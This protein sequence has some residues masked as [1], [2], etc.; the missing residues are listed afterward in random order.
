MVTPHCLSFYLLF[1]LNQNLSV[2]IKIPRKKNLNQ[3]SPGTVRDI[4]TGVIVSGVDTLKLST[5]KGFLLLFAI[6]KLLDAFL[7]A[8][9]TTIHAKAPSYHPRFLKVNPTLKSTLF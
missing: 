2:P 6:S 9:P 1:K 3:V 5:S 7:D 4:V 8:L